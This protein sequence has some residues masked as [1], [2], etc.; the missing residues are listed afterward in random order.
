VGI[1]KKMAGTSG[2][3]SRSE[4]NKLQETKKN[5]NVNNQFNQITDLKRKSVIGPHRCRVMPM[6]RNSF[7]DSRGDMMSW[8]KRS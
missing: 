1:T 6:S 3:G 7:T 8:P 2:M 5:K 4:C